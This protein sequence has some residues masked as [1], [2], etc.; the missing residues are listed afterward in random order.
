[1]VASGRQVGNRKLRVAV[2][3]LGGNGSRFAKLYSKHPGVDLVAACD[4]DEKRSEFASGLGAD[5]LSDY[6]EVA[7]LDDLD[8]VSVHLPDRIHADAALAAMDAGKHVFVEKPMA[9]TIEDCNAMI[10]AMDRTGLCVAVGQVLRTKALYKRIKDVVDSGVLGT[11][12]YCEGDYMVHEFSSEAEAAKVGPTYS[13]QGFGCSAT[14][15]LDI[16]RWYLGNPT[17]VMAMGNIGMAHPSHPGDGFIAALYRWPNGCIGRVTGT[18]ACSYDHSYENAYGISLFGSEASI[19]R[20]H[21]VSPDGDNEP[22]ELA[23]HGRGHPFDDEVDDFVNAVLSGCAPATD[24][25]DGGNTAIAIIC[26][27]KAMESGET[28]AIPNR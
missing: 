5:F 20:G 7:A 25:R 27:I 8:V 1:M 17:D 15:P 16:L 11:I 24:A 18:W 2:A 4:I 6:Q 22:V 10:D 21:L 26:G 12:Y 23:S 28:V 3:G 9:T 13:L 14:H 19:V